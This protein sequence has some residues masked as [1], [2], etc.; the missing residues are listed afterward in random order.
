[1]AFSQS[2]TLIWWFFWC[3]RWRWSEQSSNNYSKKSATLLFSLNFEGTPTTKKILC[4]APKPLTPSK[5]WCERLESA[6]I[7]R[8]I[9][10]FLF[11]NSSGIS[12]AVFAAKII[13]HSFAKHFVAIKR[14]C[15]QGND[16]EDYRQIWV[17]KNSEKEALQCP[18][19]EKKMWENLK[20]AQNFSKEIG[21]NWAEFWKDDLN[22]WKATKVAVQFE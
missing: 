22:L 20:F 19:F 2:C 16:G 15:S 7:K 6:S 17:P 4:F 3:Y 5:Q 21:R 8:V 14:K 10:L 11:S 1:M 13:T 9:R 18:H 12:R